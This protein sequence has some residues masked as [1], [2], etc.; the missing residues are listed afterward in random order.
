LPYRDTMIGWKSILI[1]FITLMS[2]LLSVHKCMNLSYSIDWGVNPQEWCI[3]RS[4]M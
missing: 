3:K 1:I 2:T 4:K